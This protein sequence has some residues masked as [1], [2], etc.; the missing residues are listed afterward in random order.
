MEIIQSV[1]KKLSEAKTIDDVNNI[2]DSLQVEDKYQ[3]DDMTYPQLEFK[4]TKNEIQKLKNDSNTIIKIG[5]R[6]TNK[7]NSK[8]SIDFPIESFWT[9]ETPTTANT[10]VHIPRTSCKKKEL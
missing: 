9:S 5:T 3:M 2:L 6:I 7:G 4:I 8:F 10:K 1:F